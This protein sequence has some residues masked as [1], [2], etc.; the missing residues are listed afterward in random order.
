MRRRRLTLQPTHRQPLR[1]WHPHTRMHTHPCTHTHARIYKHPLKCI[2]AFPSAWLLWR[3]VRVC[4]RVIQTV[5]DWGGVVG[6]RTWVFSYSTS[7]CSAK[8]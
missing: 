4:L 2:V 5:W 1:P 3:F 8:R 6:G 7:R